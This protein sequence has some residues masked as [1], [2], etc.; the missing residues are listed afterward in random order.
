MAL[1][2]VKSALGTTVPLKK[3]KVSSSAS[4]VPLSE[5]MVKVADWVPPM[6]VEAAEML[7]AVKVST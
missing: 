3:I 6:V 5:L 7:L 2:H 1:F 4:E